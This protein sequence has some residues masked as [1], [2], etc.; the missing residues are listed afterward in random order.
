MEVESS[1]SLKLASVN[2][3]SLSPYALK[4]KPKSDVPL[5]YLSIHFTSF[6]SF[7]VG[8]LCFL[9]RKM[10]AYDMSGLMAPATYNRLSIASLYGALQGYSSTISFVILCFSI[11]HLSCY[12][13]RTLWFAFMHVKSL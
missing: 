12:H 9:E 7:S 3:S 1:Q 11:F 8:D 10:T 5:K 2:A 4:V 13:R 6:Q